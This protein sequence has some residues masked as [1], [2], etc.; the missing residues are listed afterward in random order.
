[1]EAEKTKSL[2]RPAQVE[3]LTSE[4]GNLEEMA[5]YK[6]TPNRGEVIAALRRVDNTLNEQAPKPFVGEDLDTAVKEEAQLRE[7]IQVGM[8]SQE[9]IRKNPPGAVGRLQAWEKRN[10]EK[11]LAWKHMTLRLNIGSDDPDVAN[12]ERFRPTRNTLNLDN[13]QIPGS[14]YFLPSTD[15]NYGEKH[16]AIF[17][18]SPSD[19][20]D[21]SVESLL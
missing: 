8:L 13:A 4:K 17:N 21:D 19:K 5:S 1:M 6:F 16:D 18:D 2:L 20:K 11:I 9:E 15:P 7:E 3:E 14:S 10:K 12:F